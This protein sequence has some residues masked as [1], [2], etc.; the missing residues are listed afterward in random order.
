LRY[1]CAP[2]DASHATPPLVRFRRRAGAGQTPSP[3]MGE[4][5][6]GGEAWLS[7]SIL[8]SAPHPHRSP[9]LRRRRGASLTP[10]RSPRLRRR[11]GHSLTCPLPPRGGKGQYL[12]DV[13]VVVLGQRNLVQG[14][15]NRFTQQLDRAHD[16]LRI[17][18]PLIAIDVQVAGVE[19]LDH[20]G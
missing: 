7:A 20:L 8:A 13:V 16:S 3:S 15:D 11:R 18:G 19:T 4:G 6:G 12:T 2:L 1:E 14:R 9:R 17:Y 10:P 5:R